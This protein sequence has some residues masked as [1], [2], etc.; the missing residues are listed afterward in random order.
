MYRQLIDGSV[1]EWGSGSMDPGGDTTTIT[2]LGTHSTVPV[3][4]IT[5]SGSDSNVNL[6]SVAKDVFMVESS[7]PDV[8]FTYY[9]ASKP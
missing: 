7:I 9:A 5:A 2:L 8:K 1:Y 6:V 3:V 4:I